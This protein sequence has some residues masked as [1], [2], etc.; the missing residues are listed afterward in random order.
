VIISDVAKR[1]FASHLRLNRKA[2]KMQTPT[3]C[4]LCGSEV[5]YMT[6]ERATPDFNPQLIPL[7]LRKKF[8][9]KVNGYCT[10]CGFFQNFNR[11]SDSEILRINDLGKDVLTSEGRLSNAYEIEAIRFEFYE[12]YFKL[13]LSRWRSHFSQHP[14]AAVENALFLRFWFGDSIEFAKNHFSPKTLVGV[15]MSSGCVRYTQSRFPELVVPAG[16]INGFLR[17]DFV[18]LGPYDLVFSFHLLTHASNPRSY[19]DVL[20]KLMTKNAIAVFSHEIEIKPSNPFHFNYFSEWSL[21][22]LLSE[23]FSRVERIDDC[24]SEK[25]S[26]VTDYTRKRDVPDFVCY[27]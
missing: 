4:A 12:N 16:T 10:H 3:P 14:A 2:I 5:A 1:L 9:K 21:V 19:L 23:Y 24:Q 20:T 18:N 13:R 8:L 22:S 6:G 7:D 17:G 11:L 26:Y 15:D 25:P 27:R